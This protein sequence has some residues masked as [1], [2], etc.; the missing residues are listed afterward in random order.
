MAAK[1]GPDGQLPGRYFDMLFGGPENMFELEPM[2]DV[3]AF[4][5]GWV[6]ATAAIGRQVNGGQMTAPRLLAYAAHAKNDKALGL[7]AWEKLIGNSLPPLNT[8]ARIANANV[9]KPVTDPSFIGDPVGWQLHGVAS[10]HWALNALET[11]D[12]AGPWLADWEA[13]HLDLKKV[14]P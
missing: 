14:E 12:L 10:I 6:A 11:L 9:V 2:F 5:N 7:L 4:W 3:P 13:A 8:P 1:I